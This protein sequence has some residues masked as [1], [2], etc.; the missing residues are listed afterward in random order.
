MRT[1]KKSLLAGALLG[2]ALLAGACD[3]TSPTPGGDGGTVGD[4][5][6]NHDPC[7]LG[8]WQVDVQDVADQLVALMAIP[9][10]EA[11]NEGTVTMVF[12]PTATATYDNTLT[13]NFGAAGLPMVATAVYSGTVTIADW[14]AKD[15]T[16]TGSEPT[17]DFD[18]DL[19][20]TAGGQTIPAPMELPGLGEFGGPTPVGYTCSGDS[21]TLTPPAPAPTW[22]LSRS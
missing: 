20:F 5:N 6:P 7:L 11:V 17:G 8:T 13:L 19:T 9:G 21:A 1:T 3:S 14:T 16:F 4:G 18:I 12:G 10:G 22:R 15:G 2:V